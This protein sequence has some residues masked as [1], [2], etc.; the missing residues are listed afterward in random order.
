MYM[1][2]YLINPVSDNNYTINYMYCYLLEYLG[3][4]KDYK[5][6]PKIYN[7]FAF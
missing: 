3:F 7:N 6:T 1:F 4:N 2:L 5:F